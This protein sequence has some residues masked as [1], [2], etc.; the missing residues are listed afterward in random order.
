MTIPASRR[1]QSRRGRPDEL[2]ARQR[3]F[4]HEYLVDLNARAA[5]LRVGYAEKSVN[6]NASQ[7]LRMPK[8]AELIAELMTER[9]K[10][11]EVREDRVLLE[12]ARL[13]F[14]DPRKA[15]DTDGNILPIQQ[16]PDEVAAAVSSIKILETKSG[17]ETL[18]IQ[19]KEIKFWDKSKNLDLAARHLGMLKDKLELSGNVQFTLDKDDQNA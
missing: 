1:K 8:V 2:T 12:I 16:W 15:F 3:E 9:S 7:L 10:R 5:A 19:T 11:I 18:S 13:A 17:D 6:T 14:N 4:C